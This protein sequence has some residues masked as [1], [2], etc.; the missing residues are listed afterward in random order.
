M[1]KEEL[2]LLTSSELAE[3]A[4]EYASNTNPYCDAGLEPIY[5]DLDIAE[6]YKAGFLEAVSILAAKQS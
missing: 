5:S 1:S 2:S 3:A 6:A 4:K